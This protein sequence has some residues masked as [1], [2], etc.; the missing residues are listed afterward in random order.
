MT[1]RSQSGIT[2]PEV[3]VTTTILVVLAA[4]VLPTIMSRL[5]ASRGA[6][7]VTEIA[8]LNKSLQTFRKDVGSYPRFLDYLS[9]MP[10]TN[11]ETYCST[12]L[13]P[14]GTPVLFFGP[15]LTAWQG[16]YSTRTITGDYTTPEGNTI[17]DVMTYTAPSGSAPAYL[18]IKINGVSAGVAQYIEDTID[19]P[20]GSFTAGMFTWDQVNGSYRIPVPTCP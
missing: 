10:A 15:P 11:A 17:E 12:G 13:P 14:F 5:D 8:G 20:P 6:A 2:L 4:A 18:V 16:P 9:A 7:I 19:G 3:L 1:T